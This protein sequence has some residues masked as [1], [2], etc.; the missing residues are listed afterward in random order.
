MKIAEKAAKRR[1]GT[2][3]GLFLQCA[4][5]AFFLCFANGLSA[6]KKAETANI[7]GESKAVFLKRSKR[8]FVTLQNEKVHISADVYSEMLHLKLHSAEL[9]NES[10]R[11]SQFVKIKNLKAF[12]LAPQGKSFRKLPVTNFSTGDIISEDV[13]YN[14]EK[15]ITFTF[16]SIEPGAKTIV[17]YTEEITEPHFLGGFSFSTYVQCLE[18]EV[19]VWV[20]KGVILGY[21]LFNETD[22]E[23]EIRQNSKFQIYR[24]RKK[25]NPA[26][27]NYSNVPS[28]AYYEPHIWFHVKAFRVKNEYKRVLADVSDLYAWYYGFI[29]NADLSDNRSLLGFADSLC[30]GVKESEEK[31]KIIFRWV[32]SH[33]KYV[34]FEQGL[35]GFTPE[36]AENVFSKR[37]GDC[38]DMSSL[39]TALLRHAGLKAHFAWVGSRDLPYRYEELPTPAVD[40]HM[41]VVVFLDT[42]TLFLDA[43]S[44]YVPFGMPTAFIQG[45]EALV[46][47]DEK[48]YQILNVPVMPPAKNRITDSVHLYI[49][50]SK[51]K[52]SGTYAM[53]GYPRVIF[54]EHIAEN[55]ENQV[56]SVRRLLEGENKFLDSLHYDF[57]HFEEN[58]LPLFLRYYWETSNYHKLGSGELYINLHLQPLWRGKSLSDKRTV[59][60]ETQYHFEQSSAV[61]LHVPPGYTVKAVPEATSFSHP[62]FAFEVNYELSGDVVVM[63]SKI[64]SSYLLLQRDKFPLWNEMISKVN[65]AYRQSLLLH[66]KGF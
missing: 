45:K 48:T 66:E 28:P 39:L 17:S 42:K 64:R 51:L 54:T 62:D 30:R 6:Q 24:W 20:Q 22:T 4:F 36:F 23:F 52:A 38:K 37:Y 53:T 25:N 14:D 34:A 61:F 1:N 32:Q 11:F 49:E 19:E 55:S 27:P 46:A 12:T 35:R 5:F 16:P 63:R 13:F 2:L 7:F 15:E 33:V 40:D 8:I 47:I 60:L 26:P 31:A 44:H 58:N 21:K 56:R 43:T 59:P 18:S 9:A 41:I 50:K 3:C 29:R 57:D 10:V 65:A